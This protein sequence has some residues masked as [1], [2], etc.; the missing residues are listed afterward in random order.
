MAMAA[1]AA[2]RALV[3]A[4]AF[5]FAGCADPGPATEPGKPGVDRVSSPGED[6]APQDPPVSVAQFALI[7]VLHIPSARVADPTCTVWCALR[8]SAVTMEGARTLNVSHE[9]AG[10]KADA[11]WDGG[12]VLRLCISRDGAQ[13]L[14][15]PCVEGPSPLHLDWTAPIEEPEGPGLYMLTHALVG[16]APGFSERLEGRLEV[17]RA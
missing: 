9:V 3:L 13:A 15:I 4:V 12:S 16:P 2:A 14:A 11:S 5:L 8:S 10:V 7:G 1:R 6:G 17:L